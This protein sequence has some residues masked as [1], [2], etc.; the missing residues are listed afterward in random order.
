MTSDHDAL[1]RAICENPREDTPRLVFADWLEE[2]GHAKR[3]AFIRND[4]AMSLR[5][6]WDVERLRWEEGHQAR[7]TL[8]ASWSGVLPLPG[9]SRNGVSWH[10]KE[11]QLFRR[12]FPSVLHV[13]D[14]LEF[15][16][17]A[18]EL[19]ST[20]PIEHL[21]FQG[22]LPPIS[23]FVSEPWFPKV[24]GLEWSAGRLSDVMLRP[25]LEAPN[26]GLEELGIGG[27]GV[28]SEGLRAVFALPL[29]RRLLRLSL[30]GVSATEVA[31]CFEELGRPVPPCRLRSLSFRESALSASVSFFADRIPI[32]LPILDITSARLNSGSTRVFADSPYLTDLRVLTMKSNN[33]GN[34]G[35]TA[36]F[37]SPHLAG[38]KVLDLSYCMVG[39]EALR[40]LLENSPLVDGLNLLTLTGS[41]A[42]AD[43]KQAVKD[44]MGDR[45]RL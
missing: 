24:T 12:G 45:V 39:D 9:M 21:A 36:I 5:D 34:G 7:Q 20:H 41:P 44:R 1:L 3:A 4:I 10:W 2:H 11:W 40:A 28:N 37:T 6:E 8:L 14:L 33:V 26:S 32:G 22:S 38:L 42:S 31:Q 19:F 27:T 15:R 43:M 13:S 25:L 17:R 35:A 16:A 29:F 18:A 30:T 23:R